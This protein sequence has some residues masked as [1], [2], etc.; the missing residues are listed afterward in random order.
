VLTLKLFLGLLV[1][2]GFVDIIHRGYILFTHQTSLV[3]GAILFLAEVG[4]WIWLVT[5]LR[6]PKY[7]HSK[8]SFK[9]TFV[10]VLAIVLVCA[11]A[12]IEPLST[13]KDNVLNKITTT[14]N[15]NTSTPN[16]TQGILVPT[17]PS[18]TSEDT[19]TIPKSE[20]TQTGIKEDVAPTENNPP[21]I[22][23]YETI[24]N[25]YRVQ[26]GLRPLVFTS[27]LNNL[28]QK[29]AMEIQTNFSHEGIMK[30]NLG[31]N[32]VMGI[33]SDQE[34]LDIW[35]KSPGHKANM[36]DPQYTKTGYCRNGGYAVQLFSW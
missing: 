16:N 32:I 22:A 17:I 6:R 8:P 9:L 35:D 12:G 33:S 3:M 25:N 23:S 30:Y 29:R 7:R 11:F 18:T 26:H 31:E 14:L 1:I 10:S 4:F 34:A 28:A 19:T 21:I 13:Y 24:F 15:S 27:E 20:D 2:A 5:V 36:L